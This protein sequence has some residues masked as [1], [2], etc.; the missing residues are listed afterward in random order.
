MS[1][2][3]WDD[4]TGYT[5]TQ[6]LE[7]KG[8]GSS[9]GI[10]GT[11]TLDG[12][13]GLF[14]DA[15]SSAN[16]GFEVMDIGDSRSLRAHQDGLTG[17]RSSITAMGFCGVNNPTGTEV[18]ALMDHDQGQRSNYGILKAKNKPKIFQISKFKTRSL[19]TRFWKQNDHNFLE[20]KLF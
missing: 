10:K 20:N 18:K 3:V 11:M 1:A 17:A 12:L 15:M 5:L 13:A 19:E 8:K 2:H 16:D 7:G 14:T 6:E 9:K 4:T